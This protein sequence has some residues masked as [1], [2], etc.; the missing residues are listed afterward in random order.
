MELRGGSN[1]SVTAN[2]CCCILTKYVKDIKEGGLRQREESS[3]LG[4]EMASTTKECG[5]TGCGNTDHY[6][7]C[8][9]KI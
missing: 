8:V 2:A 9:G 6:M 3:F 5:T 7:N 4:W 1:I